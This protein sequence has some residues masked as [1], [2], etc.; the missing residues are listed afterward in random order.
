M[1]QELFFLLG[2]DL[3]SRKMYTYALPNKANKNI[4]L[5]FKTI[6]KKVGRHPKYITSDAGSE[7]TSK[8]AQ[9]YFKANNI[10]W[11]TTYGH[12]SII[13]RANQTLMGKLFALMIHNGNRKWIKL[14]PII[15]DSYNNTS[16]RSLNYLSPNQVNNETSGLVFRSLYKELIN[17]TFKKVKPKF[18]VNEPVRIALEKGVF[19]K[20][21]ILFN[22]YP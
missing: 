6:F 17:K 19:E 18:K 12:S 9:N 2:I 21:G 11:Y 20:V 8:I 1:I 4:I 13:E 3:F 10:H 5:G 7:F 15:T 16:H 14:L 22:V